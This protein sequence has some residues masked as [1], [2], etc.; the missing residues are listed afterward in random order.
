MNGRSQYALPCFGSKPKVGNR[1]G[2][3][4]FEET[5]SSDAISGSKVVQGSGLQGPLDILMAISL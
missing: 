1:T 3:T 2:N 5:V 4:E